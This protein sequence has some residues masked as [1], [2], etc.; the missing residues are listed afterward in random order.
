MIYDQKGSRKSI[1]GELTRRV[2]QFGYRLCLED[3]SSR[4]NHLIRYEKRIDGA[5]FYVQLRFMLPNYLKLQVQFSL[6]NE[7]VDGFFNL[8][9]TLSE[10]R[11]PLLIMNFDMDD[12]ISERM[13][14]KKSDFYI[15]NDS[16]YGGV[17]AEQVAGQIVDRYFLYVEQEFASRFSSLEE[18]EDVINAP[19]HF[20]RDRLVKLSAYCYPIQ[21]QVLAGVALPLFCKKQDYKE[22]LIK[23]LNYC[24]LDF[25]K[26]EDEDIAA[27]THYLK[28]LMDIKVED[29]A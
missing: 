8:H 7:W 2:E 23:Y 10:D 6:T 24:T 11:R 3:Y 16:G 14:R 22:T 29:D 9:C 28:Q 27:L 4:F 25:K 13:N 19:E 15:T 18:I 5:T 21:N 12:Y 17:K 26:G 1:I 20:T